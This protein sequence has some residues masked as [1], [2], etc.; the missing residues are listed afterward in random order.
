MRAM[1]LDSP[2]SPL[3]VAEVPIP[4]AGPKQVLLQVHACAVCR[5]DLHV[6]D[7]ELPDPTL[8]LIPGHQIVGTVK[9]VGERADRFAAGDRV[10]VPWLGHTD[11]TCCY[12]LT[13]RE[14]LCDAARY[15]GY[16]VNGLCR[17]HSGRP[18]LLL[19]NSGG[20]SRPPSCAAVVRGIDRLPLP[21]SYR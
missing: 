1:V 12:C 15:T 14:N 8:P 13:G 21:E 18:P 5:T 9:R 17:I 10:G 16:Q 11:G 3:R 20:E 19:P 2:G 6:V 7:S 4:E